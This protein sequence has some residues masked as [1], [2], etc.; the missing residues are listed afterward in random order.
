MQRCLAA[1]PTV[2][3]YPE[4]GKALVF[5]E[6]GP[7][8]SSVDVA[9]LEEEARVLLSFKEMSTC[10]PKYGYVLSFLV[11]QEKFITEADRMRGIACS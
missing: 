1:G 9:K 6:S 11:T 8:Q 10:R 7:I 2:Y 5:A 4:I 3:P